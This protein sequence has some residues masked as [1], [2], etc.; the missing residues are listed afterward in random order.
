MSQLAFGLEARATLKSELSASNF[1]EFGT[2][3]TTYFSN[4]G[5]KFSKPGEVIV[6][7][8]DSVSDDEND[9]TKDLLDRLKRD[10]QEYAAKG[11]DEA[12]LQALRPHVMN[13]NSP[14]SSVASYSGK[15]GDI[16]KAIDESVFRLLRPQVSAYST[17][18]DERLIRL[19]ALASTQTP[20]PAKEP[21][22]PPLGP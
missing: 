6:V 3:L 11:L 7:P 8:P 4:L 22:E 1:Q 5:D 15:K 12:H 17:Q 9:E 21:V 13:G 14:R 20:P 10:W 19:E 2:K 16:E 18:L